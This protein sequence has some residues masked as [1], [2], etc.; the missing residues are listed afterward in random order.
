MS[1]E[2]IP[3]FLDNGNTLVHLLLS[4][5]ERR[6]KSDDIS[7]SGFSNKAVLQKQCRKLVSNVTILKLQPSEESFASELSDSGTDTDVFHI[8]PE[9]LS[10]F[11]RILYHAFFFDDFDGSLGDSASEGTS[12]IGRTMLSR[13]DVVHYIVVCKHC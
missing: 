2:L 6:R 9:V 8:V 5:A 3:G 10:H 7:L 1:F 4:D 11:K 12:A 13:L